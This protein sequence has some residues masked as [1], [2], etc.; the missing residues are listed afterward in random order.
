MIS[1]LIFI[2]QISCFNS[3]L[4]SERTVITNGP[5]DQIVNAS[6]IVIFPCKAE[7][8]DLESS[9]LAIEWRINGEKIDYTRRPHLEHN[10]QNNSL[11]ITGVEASDSASYTC[12]AAN[13]VD[14]TDATA[15]LVVRG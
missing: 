15:R 9:N 13:G 12:H 4:F 10:K 8:D 1:Q 2:N 11:I 14:R 3:Q 6:S 7:T 5:K